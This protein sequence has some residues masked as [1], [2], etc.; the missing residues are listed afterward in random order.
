MR[1]SSILANRANQ[2]GGSAP[3]VGGEGSAPKKVARVEPK[4]V[5][6]PIPAPS[7]PAAPRASALPAG[8]SGAR[9]SALPAG[10]K[11][12][13]DPVKGVAAAAVSGVV[14]RR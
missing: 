12:K 8:M 1:K 5:T 7:A 3:R 4:E 14:K 2:S 13:S 9:T 11:K 6:E 10:M